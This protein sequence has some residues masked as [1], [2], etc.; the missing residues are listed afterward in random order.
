MG[1]DKLEINTK[2]EPK[3]F[4]RLCTFNLQTGADILTDAVP[5]PS[6][7]LVCDQQK[8]KLLVLGHFSWSYSYLE[9]IFSESYTIRH[10][11]GF[12]QRYEQFHFAD[13]LIVANSSVS[14]SISLNANPDSKFILMR[15]WFL[16]PDPK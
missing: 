12:V 13:L 16:D 8:G 9:V 6:P 15:I 14:I 7:S 1:N 5:V 11:A 3:K 4:S 10:T 2:S